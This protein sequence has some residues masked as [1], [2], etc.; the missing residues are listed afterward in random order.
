MPFSSNSNIRALYEF[1]YE[2]FKKLKV[3]CKGGGSFYKEM[4][5]KG[6]QKTL[7]I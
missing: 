2:S 3:F 4:K 1:F 5:L 6:E 7:D